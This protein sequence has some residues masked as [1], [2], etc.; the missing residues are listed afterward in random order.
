[1]TAGV[2]HIEDM[3]G[4]AG[5]HELIRSSW[6]E[7]EQFAE[8]F[9]R[10]AEAIH[11]YLARRIGR[12][13][14]DDLVGET[15]LVAFRRREGYDVSQTDARPWLY[16]IAANLLHREQRTEVR[17]YRALA[18]TGLDPVLD[19]TDGVLARVAAEDHVR[20]LATVLARLSVREREVLTLVG[21]AQLSY[22]EVARA[23]GI[24]VGTVRSRLHS[25]RR[26]IRE[27][28]RDHPELNLMN[29]SDDE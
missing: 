9:D 18:R 6:T 26:R 21:Q 5:D 2:V 29:G 8:I 7:P 13:V 28:L 15:F 1:M 19:D 17:Q 22:P 10:H 11:R 27:A 12:S 23:L 20:K 25:A 4:M 14:A 16:G 3:T 24:P